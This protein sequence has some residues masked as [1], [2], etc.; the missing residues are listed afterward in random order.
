MSKQVKTKKVKL[1]SFINKAIQKME[2]ETYDANVKKYIPD[3]ITFCESP[4]YLD[5]ASRGIKLR[6]AQRVV[7]KIFYRGSSGN[8]DLRLTQEEIDWCKENCIHEDEDNMLEKY[9]TNEVFRELVLAWGRRCVSG[10]SKI[11]D[12]LTG[13]RWKIEDLWKQNKTINAWTYNE[14]EQK[15]EKIPDCNIIYQG[16][17]DIF[18]VKTVAGQEIKV[19][20][21]H[22]FLTKSGWKELRN[23]S[24][25]D[26]IA[27]TTSVPFF[28]NSKAITEDEAAILGY[29]T[30][31]GCCSQSSTYFTCSSDKIK[32]DIEDRLSRAFP[33]V[34]MIKD[35]WTSAKSAQYQYKFRGKKIE[36]DKYFNEKRNQVM[37]KQKKI[38]LKE[39]LIKHGISGMTCHNKE[40]PEDLYECPKNV[41][42]SYLRSLYS[43]DGNITLISNGAAVQVEM[44][45]VNLNQANAVRHLLLRFG[46]YATVRKKECKTQIA[47]EVKSYNSIS[48]RVSFSRSQY[49]KSFIENIGFIDRD[50]QIKKAKEVIF[51]EKR[52]EKKRVSIS[53]QK[54][55]SIDECG[56]GDTFDLQVSDEP[57][58]QNFIAN[59]IV[60][61][62]SGKD[63]LS[64]IIAPYEAMRLIECNGGNPYALYTGGLSSASPICILTIATAKEQANIAY[65]EIKDRITHSQYFMSKIGPEGMESTKIHLLTPAD[66]E[67]N[68]KLLA[69]GFPLKKGSI[70]IEV[71]HSNS[72]SLLGKSVFVLILDEVASYK[73]TGGSSSGERIYTAMSPALNTF[74]RTELVFDDLG[75]PVVDENG[76]QKEKKVYDSKIISISSPRGKE[77]IFW[78]I[79]KDAP[80]T[81]SRIA[82]RLPTWVANPNLTLESLRETN[83]SMTEEQFMTEF[84]AEFSGTAGENM[85]TKDSIDEAF[86]N[87]LKNKAY[88]EPNIIYYAHLDPATSSHNYALVVLHK[89]LYFDQDKKEN[90]YR[91]IVDH[92]KYWHPTPGNP[93]RTEVITD[94]LKE[95][96]KKFYIGMV[97][98]D[99]WNSLDSKTMLRKNGIPHKLTH[100]SGSYK[101]I[102]YTELYNLLLDG[103]IKIPRHDLLK[104]EMTNLQKKRT[105]QNRFSVFCKKD[106][107]YNTDD[108]ID[109]LAGACYTA[110][111]LTTKKLPGSRLIDTGAMSSSNQMQ[112]NCM[113]GPIGYGTGKQVSDNLENRSSWI[114]RQRI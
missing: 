36:Y 7:L 89:E 100:F 107:E 16:K 4:E 56:Q 13:K 12:P 109:A 52:K 44:Y 86:L 11:V 101:M 9:E 54:I 3:I 22:P 53:F 98:F 99:L 73:T 76:K 39:L 92:I 21:N 25:G 62:N 23:L 32:K 19:T 29:I 31:D 18:S 87:S 65:Q 30:G 79:F 97:T 59:D 42:A 104:G 50:E 95:L 67:L 77:G 103:R 40:V 48:Y 102:I 70:I 57:H 61:H 20:R 72:D 2:F 78:D 55:K 28:G 82:C 93:I 83:D 68:K 63:F 88:G 108:V 66:I 47:R 112:W 46:I 49:V 74:V 106:A 43:C 26:K 113:S 80:L 90:N 45:T 60:L 114:N 96:K 15:M 111:S 75:N 84:G 8:E 58:K 38:S 81:K 51:A 37:V 35:T 41:I 6:M 85:F 10:D 17:R 110:L 91:I 1:D 94:Y 14:Q 71:G 105:S 33:D 24:I 34:E 5:L 69:Q 27:V 64:G